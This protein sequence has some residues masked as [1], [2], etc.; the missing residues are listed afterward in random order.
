MLSILF[1]MA[2]LLAGISGSAAAEPAPVSIDGGTVQGTTQ[3]KVDVWLGIPYAAPP[4]GALRW[5][6]PQPVVPWNATLTTDTYGPACFQPDIEFVS[7]D[8]L[9]LNVFRPAGATGPL[10]VMVWIHGGAMVRGAS[11]LYPLQA[12]AGQGVVGVSINYRLGRLGFFAHPALALDGEP[13]GN[14]GYLDQLAA[15]KWVRKNIAAFGGDPDNV[16]IFGESAGGGSVFAQM[17]SPMSRGLFKRAIAESPGT[18]GGR[19][20]EIPSS[21]LEQ[22]EKIAVDY[23]EGLGIEGTDD[24]SA[25]RLRAL[26]PETLVAGA[27]GPEVLDALGRRTVV[28]GMAMSII[29]GQFLTEPVESALKDG[30]W[31]KV[32]LIIGANSRDLGLGA[33]MTKEALFAELGPNADKARALYDP[34]GTESLDELKVQV[35]MDMTMLEP[36]QHVADLVAASGEP[37][38]LYRFSYVP[39]VQRPTM[40]GTLH[41]MEIPY[42]LDVPAAIVGAAN[43]SDEDRAIGAAAS[44]YWLNF[45]KTGN[46]NGA[47]LPHWPQHEPGSDLVLDFSNDGIK[48]MDDPRAAKIDLWRTFQ[49]GR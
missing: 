16:T 41:G 28:P 11:S 15:L 40:P 3:G 43:V 5:R 39:T 46:P 18:P 17:I 2:A 1:A 34:N 32:P 13:R 47:G 37:T 23:A 45:A 9:T 36:A 30:N 33:D 38:W 10:P 29:D 20:T 35:Y 6:P 31:A 4:I 22:A 27:S 12:L 19:P 14:Y 26:S 49:D 24:A 42:V 8:C 48:A 44:G 7:E 21:T 25:E